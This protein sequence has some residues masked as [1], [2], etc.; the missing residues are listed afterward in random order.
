MR[1]DAHQHFWRYNHEEYGWLD[2]SMRALRRDF[3]VE[4]LKPELE[5]AGFDGSI[6][7]QTRQNLE[8]TRWLLQLADR[9][10]TILGVIGWVDLCSSNV[11][12]ELA[13]F[14][15]KQKLLGVR[16]IVQSEPDQR[17]LLQP[18]FFR[19]VSTLA[20]FGLTY[21]VLIYQRHLSVAAEFVERFPEQ[22][23]VLD[24]MAK[25]R[26]R[27]RQLQPW[28]SD[29]RTLAK[30]R[31]VF[32]KVSGLV[33]EAEWSSWKPEDIIPYLDVA[34]DAFGTDRLIFGSDWPVC[35]VAASYTQVVE[36]VQEYLSR[37]AIEVRDA[38]F[39]GNA[40]RFWKL[41]AR[42]RDIA[43]RGRDGV[44]TE[45]GNRQALR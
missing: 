27:S 32:C 5:R 3:F 13:Q 7:V 36:L 4:N 16:H 21:D 9:D 43:A 35:T 30:F 31:N 40:E 45:V 29:L 2:D 23:F 18:E 1:V 37:F 34:F 12:S 33:T 6:A 25:P 26:I 19:G 20:E 22:R 38:V 11:R 15:E 42:E 39:G 44:A 10:P 17:F 8:E 41:G 24:H 14:A 28:E